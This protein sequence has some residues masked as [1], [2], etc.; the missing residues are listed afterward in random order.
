MTSKTEKVL[1][2]LAAKHNGRYAV[3]VGHFTC[4]RNGGGYGG[5]R[6]SALS[7]LI[8]RGLVEITETYS[9]RESH[10]EWA[11]HHWTVTKFRLTP[12]GEEAVRTI[13]SEE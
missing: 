3:Q 5:R 7:K 1:L 2:L 9:G 13:K 4:R 8:A 10:T 6:S 12:L 11:S